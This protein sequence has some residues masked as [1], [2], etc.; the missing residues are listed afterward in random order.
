MLHR[1]RANSED[2]PTSQEEQEEIQR[3]HPEPS[4][5]PSQWLHLVR[6]FSAS[7]HKAKAFAA[8]TFYFRDEDASGDI[9]LL[10]FMSLAELLKFEITEEVDLLKT[11]SRSRPGWGIFRGWSDTATFV[12][13]SAANIVLTAIFLIHPTLSS[14]ENVNDNGYRMSDANMGWI[15][16]VLL[17]LFLFEVI[18]RV[19]SRGMRHQFSP[20]NVFNFYESAILLAATTLKLLY[21]W[22][23]ASLLVMRCFCLLRWSM[24]QPDSVM[25]WF[26]RLTLAVFGSSIR[27]NIYSI[28]LQIKQTWERTS[29]LFLYTGGLLFLVQYFFSVLGTM[30]IDDKLAPINQNDN[31]PMN[32]AYGELT[33]FATVGSSMVAMF[34]IMLT[35]NWNDIL[36]TSV[37][38][39]HSAIAAFFIIYY[40]LVPL[41]FLNIFTS[42]VLQ[43]FKMDNINNETQTAA[44]LVVEMDGKL[45]RLE[46]TGYRRGL[47]L[48]MDLLDSTK[49][50][51]M[52]DII[53]DGVFETSVLSGVEEELLNER[54]AFAILQLRHEKQ[55][56]LTKHEL[57][58]AHSHFQTV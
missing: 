2:S 35:N 44:P 24:W 19:L 50:E 27:M 39:T 40:I 22:R 3:E 20:H 45:Y 42:I 5:S 17:L 34:Q 7:E 46:R 26:D 52:Q 29:S 38:A 37:A 47:E 54:Q 55:K 8:V 57:D 25:W 13:L 6:F 28:M 51:L 58:F 43:S 11:K 53:R 4:V 12:S 56:E 48:H 18:V 31:A 1:S 30:I 49:Q 15:S 21:G 9:S 16:T 36:Y 33:N 32:G 41:L 23:G 10:E 14:H